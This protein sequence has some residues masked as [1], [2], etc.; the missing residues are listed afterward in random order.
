MAVIGWFEHLGTTTEAVA[1]EAEYLRDSG[2]ADI[3]AK[4]PGALE[5]DGRRL[6]ADGM[7][8]DLVYRHGLTR[9]VLAARNEVKPL[10]TAHRQNAVYMVNPFHAEL[11]GHKA[12]LALL[13]DPDIDLGLADV[14]REVIGL[15][16]LSM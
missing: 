11:M 8:I 6:V 4:E 10:L 7:A 3:I 2:I 9:D 14:E 12:L 13:T 15:I 5:F 1:R 16:L